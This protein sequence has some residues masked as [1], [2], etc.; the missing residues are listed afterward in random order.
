[1]PSNRPGLS[2]C[3]L[4]AVVLSVGA[5][6][7]DASD[8]GPQGGTGGSGG[9]G[10]AIDPSLL[11]LEGRVTEPNLQPVGSGTVYLV[12][13]ND[14]AQLAET[15]IDLFLSPEATATLQVDEPIED[16]LTANGDAYERAEVDA[17]G[18]YRFETLPEGRQF[19]VWVPEPGDD[20]HFPG[21]DNCRVSFPRESLL[22]MQMDIRVS[23]RPS[24][25]ATY[26]GSRTC[27]LCHRDY[28]TK[29]T[30]H[31]VGLQVP[32]QRS[33]MQDVGPWPDFD[34]GL[35]A[36]EAGTTLYYYDCNAAAEAASKCAVSDSPPGGEVSFEVRLRRNAA[37]PQGAI[38]AYYVEIANRQSA[39]PSRRYDVV[40]TYGGAV[41][42]QEYLTRRS[43]DN[44]SFS[45]FV[46]PIDY[47]YQGE[48]SN[49]DPDDWPW[50]DYRSD[51]WYDFER[52]ALSEP[53][54][55]AS[56]DN[57]CA[58]C[59]FTA[60]RLEGSEAQGWSAAALA[61]PDGSFDYD[62][63]GELE[64]I[65][66]GCEAC[67]GPG[68]E[69]LDS[70][71]R[72]RYIVS[73]GLLTPGRAAALCG[74]CH[75]R[76]LG[77]G[78]GGTGLPLSAE[79]QMPPPGIRRAEFAELHTTRVSGAKEDFFDSGDAKAHYQQYSDHI[80]SAHYRNPYRLTTCTGCHD[81]HRNPSD[82]AEM[83]TS[84]NP[85]ALCTTCHSPAFSPELYPV[86][87]HAAEATGFEGHASLEELLGP[88]LC[89]QCHMVPSAKSGAGV[90]ALLD[91]SGGPP[92]VQYYWNDIA[93]H[94]MSVT[95][96][97]ESAGQPD[98]PIAFTNACGQCHA[99][100]LPNRAA[101]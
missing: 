18:F 5:C 82:L 51:L 2:L 60:Y 90:P 1:M 69:H 96:W 61:D 71:P 38:G 19:V 54:N 28:D 50:R 24:A 55:E 85:N 4:V 14:V 56:F 45:Y 31:S 83:D 72:S 63:D 80:R 78:G 46:L 75:S 84:G 57:N 79:D 52:D 22:G 11:G 58:G 20:A 93:S 44:G 30:A 6:N 12:P 62:G 66:L 26:I 9:A 43:N 23:S 88:Y 67:H 7:D 53:P 32:G 25:A 21:G 64:L 99:G 87:G 42:R 17:D 92:T 65:N 39:E 27:M 89:T 15:P 76:P 73:P 10:G 49:P 36:F 29:R 59:H 8:Q 34:E 81:P 3:L 47:A 74:S 97:D 77:I 94:R 37:L 35:A 101:P 100:F 13:A 16:L 70:S 98:Q 91:A 95:P 33:S 41:H 40:L 48:Y 68:S 86:A